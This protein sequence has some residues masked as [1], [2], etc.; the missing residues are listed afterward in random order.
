MK[1]YKEISPK[2]LDKIILSASKNKKKSWNYSEKGEKH[3]KSP[4]YIEIEDVVKAA[5]GKEKL[6]K[7]FNYSEECFNY[8]DKVRQKI[9]L[10]RLKKYDE[11]YSPTIEGLWDFCD[12]ILP[13]SPE[14]EEEPEEKVERLLGL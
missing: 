13:P 14:R 7:M 4:R 3:R 8:L 9:E 1:E 10:E 11:V 5:G 12:S 6:K 2:D